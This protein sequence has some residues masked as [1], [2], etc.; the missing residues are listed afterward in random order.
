MRRLGEP[1]LDL[2]AV[3]AQRFALRHLLLD[4]PIEFLKKFDRVVR[5]LQRTLGLLRF[6]IGPFHLVDDRMQLLASLFLHHV[7]RHHTEPNPF[8]DP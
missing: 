1:G 4:N 2:Q 3:C 7:L 6:E 8:V 5:R